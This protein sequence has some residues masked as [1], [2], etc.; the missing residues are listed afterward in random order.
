MKT[1]YTGLLPMGHTGQV[2]MDRRCDAAGATTG[3]AI[4]QADFSGM[5]PGKSLRF[6][7]SNRLDRD[8]VV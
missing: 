4:H 6:N 3:A 5:K 7:R 2:G 8:E 1:G